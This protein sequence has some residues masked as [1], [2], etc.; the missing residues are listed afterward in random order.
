MGNN[1]VVRDH[2]AL[3]SRK[4]YAPIRIVFELAHMGSSHSKSGVDEWMDFYGNM[5]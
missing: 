1:Q 3:G 2:Y 4:R 5:P